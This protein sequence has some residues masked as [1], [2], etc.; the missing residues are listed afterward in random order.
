M[1]RIDLHIHTI[2][3]PLDDEFS[4][5]MEALREHVSHNGLDAIAITNHNLFDMRNYKE[6]CEVLPEATC[7]LPGIEVSVKGYHVI[8]VASPANVEVFAQSC[9]D[10]PSIRQGEDGIPIDEFSRLF[11]DGSYI[12]I[13][14]YKKRP[15]I[16]A[17]DLAALG[18]IV[19]A[20]EVSSEKKWEYEHTRVD[21]PVV[22]FSDF[23]CAS[24][25]KGSWGRYT[26][27]TM[28]DITFDALRLAFMDA[29][30]FSITERADHIELEPGLYA[31]LGLNVVVGGRST[32]KTFFLNKVFN[33]CDSDDV[34]YVRQFDI[35]KDAEEKAFREKLN[36]EENAIRSEYYEPMAVVS[37]A[38]GEL[39]SREAIRKSIKDY[40]ADLTQFADT[41]ARDDEYS[42]CPIYSGGRLARETDNAERKVVEAIITLLDDNP[43]AQEIE[44][45]VGRDALIALL[46]IAIDRYKDKALRCKRI[47]V[48]NAIAKKIKDS[49]TIE[50]RRPACPESPLLEAARR[51]AYIKRL[52]RLRRLT[53]T[54]TVVSDKAIGKFRRITKR[55][56]YKD[57]T[58]LKAAIGTDTSMAGVLQLDDVEFIERILS[59][60]GVADISHALFDMSVALVNEQGEEVS[61]G[62]KAEYLF[63]RA[64]DRAANHDIVLI[65]EP[66]SSFDNPFLNELIAHE[67]KRISAKAT[68][69]IAT[70]NNVLGVSIK[71]DGIVY[72]SF[73]DGLHR[74]YTCDSSDDILTSPDGSSVK[75]SEVLLRLM[76]AGNEAYEGR[77]PYYG[78][79][80]N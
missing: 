79:A 78:F 26:Y 75:R 36:D 28:G 47:E 72:T 63:Y 9:N 1:K 3:T 74:I 13:P 46:R 10:V 34:V 30:K 18:N 71:P 70:H 27:V 33:S 20:L 38:I 6:I 45:T 53:K 32:G 69:F 25:P 8:V 54:E 56:P 39:P 12:V 43:L 11:G 41:S 49:L 55:I 80:Q 59:A 40:V 2:A 4:F 29:T 50:S 42:K 68:V 17:D 77:R 52:T 66:E 76:E 21:K 57:A 65:D 62:Q 35:V 31:S 24:D 60:K 58:A 48:A 73:E 23:R 5:D 14:H 51:L 67:L 64:L 16:P 15:M 61:G 44:E 7:V 19:T 37:S 22:L